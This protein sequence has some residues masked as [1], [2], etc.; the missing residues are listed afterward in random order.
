LRAFVF[1]V[2]YLDYCIYILLVWVNKWT[3]EDHVNRW[4]GN[5]GELK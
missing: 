4:I 5:F 3:S 2:N 1:M